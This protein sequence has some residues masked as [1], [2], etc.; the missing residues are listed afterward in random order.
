MASAADQHA[1]FSRMADTA[2]KG[3]SEAALTQTAVDRG[4]LAI[5]R[6]LDPLAPP[7]PEDPSLDRQAA[8][9]NARLHQRLD[10]KGA[11]LL[12]ASLN[13]PYNP[14]AAPFHYPGALD[15]SRELDCLT[16]AVYYEARGETPSGQAAV[17][18]LARWATVIA[19]CVAG[20]MIRCALARG[21]VAAVR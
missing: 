15:G 16:Q 17:A 6:R 8:Q 5:A 4:V 10:R 11:V 9:L 2:A 3:F 13:G 20:G 1:R 19:I 7:A 14:A 21:G 12:R 18:C